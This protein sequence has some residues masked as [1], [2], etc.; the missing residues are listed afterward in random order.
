MTEKKNL[1]FEEFIKQIENESW[2][3]KIWWNI[4]RVLSYFKPR[5]IQNIIKWFYQRHTRGWDDRETWDLDYTF[6][7]WL[8]DHLK[9]FVKKNNGYPDHTTYEQFTKEINNIIKEC[10]FLYDNDPYKCYNFDYDE[11]NRRRLLIL[12]W[13]KNNL[14]YLGW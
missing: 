8:R 12:D 13:F 6:F 3:E 5:K 14:Q 7:V 11:W 10:E 4:L 9:V 1:T 2:Y